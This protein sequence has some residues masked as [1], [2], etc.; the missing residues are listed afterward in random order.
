MIIIVSI[1]RHGTS[2]AEPCEPK[3][4]RPFTSVNRVH[5]SDE[6]QPGLARLGYNPGYMVRAPA[7]CRTTNTT[8][9]D[10]PLGIPVRVRYPDIKLARIACRQNSEKPWELGNLLHSCTEGSRS[11]STSSRKHICSPA[12]STKSRLLDPDQYCVVKHG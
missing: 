12:D 6:A 11:S 1:D 9:R 4:P 3:S 5:N 2:P 7:T 10:L 8:D